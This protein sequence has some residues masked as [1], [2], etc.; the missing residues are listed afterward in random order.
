MGTRVWEQVVQL[1]SVEN[2]MVIRDYPNHI[3][4]YQVLFP[5]GVVQRFEVLVC[6]VLIGGTPGLGI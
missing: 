2:L 6:K 1:I 3:Q 4:K 5:G